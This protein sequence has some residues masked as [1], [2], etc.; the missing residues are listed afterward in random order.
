MAGSESLNLDPGPDIKQILSEAKHRWLRPPEIYEI[1]RNYEKFHIFPE[2]PN[3]PQIYLCGSVFLFNRKMLR[4][5]RKDGH[6]WRKRK[7]G[8][9]IK[10]AHE[11]LKVGSVDMLNCYYAHGEDNEN[12]QRR[13]YWLLEQDLM[14]IVFVHYME[15]K[16][17]KTNI[18]CL[19][20]SV[21]V[22]STS[23]IDS[24]L[25]SS[26]RAISPTSTLLSAYA[27]SES[28]GNHQ[29]SSRFHP[30][31]DS[32][33]TE[34]IHSA[35]SSSCNQLSS[36]G[37]RNVSALKCTSISRGLGDGYFGGDSLIFGVQEMRDLGSCQ[38]DN[39]KPTTGEAAYKQDIGCSWPVDAKSQVLNNFAS[40][41]LNDAGPFYTYH[42][43][44]KQSEQR[45]I[46]MLLS[47][48]ETGNAMNPDLEPSMTTTGSENYSFLIKRPLGSLQTVES[49]K[50]VDSFSRWIAQELGEA[51]ELD[52]QSSNGIPWSMMGSECDTNL[53]AQLGVDTH[54]MNP[55]ISL[56]Q[57]FSITDFWP[58]WAYSNLETK[59]LIT[60]TFLKSED[61]SKCRW[62]IMFGEL[63]VP[64]EV[65]A[66]GILCFRAPLHTPG[67]V[68]FYVTCSNRLACS[69]LQEFEYRVGPDRNIGS[70]ITG[71]SAVVMHLY[72][73]FEA[74]LCPEPIGSPISSAGNTFEKEN[75]VNKI[76]S[77]IEE[78]TH[79]ETKLTS[80][81]NTSN[82]MVIGEL[83]LEKQL[84]DKFYTWLLYRVTADI[85][86]LTAID[87]RGQSLLHL[88]AALGFNWAFQPFM[89][90]G[91]SL[92]F[93]DVN[94][95]T[96][97]HW[98]AFCGRE[99]TVA[100]LVSL[101]ASP[102]ALTDPSSEYPQGRTPS[103]LAYSSG[104]KGISGFLGETFLTTHLSTL[105]MNDGGTTEESELEAVQTVAERLAVPT[106]EKD[107]PDALSLKDSIAAV[108]N[109][110]QAASR[111]H[112]FF[113]VQSFQ[114]KQIIEMESDK[115]LAQDDHAIGLVASKTSRLGHYDGMV[116]AA[117][118]QIQKKYRGWKKRKDFLLILQKIVKIQA[119]VRGHQVR[120]K[121][122][123]IIWSVGI[124]EKVILRWRRKGTGLRGF[125]S[126][127][128]QKNPD[129]Q[130]TLPSQ[131]DD[132]DYLKVGR[133]Q[134]EER[135]QKALS[136]VKSMA[137]YPEARAQYRRLL[138][139]A[140][141][142]R[143]NKDASD[144]IPDN[145]EDLIYPGDDL[146]DVASL[147]DDDTFM[148]L[149]F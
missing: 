16:G 60:G 67:V 69:E 86:G 47:K 8:K 84:K 149:A 129:R 64:A 11:K 62:S 106:T 2:A 137:Q 22:T 116:N 53:P 91:L 50:K 14:H 48:A 134:S 77:L 5:F 98:A 34:D 132:Y 133:K 90:S 13:S 81:T 87:E 103:D 112:Q 100:A 56:D 105:R 118:L 1:L 27:D 45:N 145:M 18:S 102:G 24:S 135:M 59:V 20:D 63:E 88:A 52:M 147:L 3:K 122:K 35:Q 104:H 74:I 148:S 31:P 138:T 94:G 41:Q 142:F 110:T 143:G 89:E 141:G 12:F 55:S 21:R 85:K 79:Q 25:S 37:N 130:E 6:N 73:R 46:Q 80:K 75:V 136:R 17:N 44:E 101:G 96:A 125:R 15:L 140:E 71:D 39:R 10:E 51:D 146:I 40:G 65:L 107:A 61:L 32:P 120:K 57:L 58:N 115:L 127:V 70:V 144:A 4:Y 83:L 97:L 26:S 29:A 36:Q 124:L 114:R 109:A 30:S 95:W 92:N 117:A 121:Y 68:T 49:L 9:T 123:P 131:E 78:E 28:E 139:A 82:R 23:E 126:D 19:N 72:Q 128:V 93:R 43:R 66:D 119:H 113:R 76:I 108:R 54:T 7:D 42:E 111:I 38:E 33:L 99:E